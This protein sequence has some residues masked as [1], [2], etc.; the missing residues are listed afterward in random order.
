MKRGETLLQLGRL[1]PACMKT[2]RSP[3]LRAKPAPGSTS[4][5]RGDGRI[6]RTGL[7]GT[8]RGLEITVV[9]NL[10]RRSRPGQARLDV[11]APHGCE[12]MWRG[13]GIGPA[14]MEGDGSD[15]V[16]PDVHPSVFGI[17]NGPAA[18]RVADDLEAFGVGVRG[19]Q[20]EA[21]GH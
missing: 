13:T 14:R 5:R 12:S 3:T 2:T 7:S 19:L 11:R 10:R 1:R 21:R 17:L 9:L 6:L 20:H 15:S 18:R 8:Y 4:S 16:R